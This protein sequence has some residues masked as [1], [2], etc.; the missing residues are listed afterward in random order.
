MLKLWFQFNTFNAVGIFTETVHKARSPAA[1]AAPSSQQTCSSAPG[2]WPGR[3]SSW[4]PG[5]L[6]ET[7]RVRLKWQRVRVM[8][9][10]VS[11]CSDPAAA[12]VESDPCYSPAGWQRCRWCPRWQVSDPSVYP[13]MGKEDRRISC[14][15]YWSYKHTHLSD[16]R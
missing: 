2:R 14:S 7:T 5:F 6:G 3:A 4:L 12:E 16:Y 9:R 1:G 10:Q 8:Y 13:L 11:L 15:Q